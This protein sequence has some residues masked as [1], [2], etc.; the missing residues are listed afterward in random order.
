[1]WPREWTTVDLIID[2]NFSPFPVSTPI[3]IKTQF[4]T[5]R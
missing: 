1:M 4:L 2:L 3:A 5:Q